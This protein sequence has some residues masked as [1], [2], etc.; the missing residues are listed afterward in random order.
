[1]ILELVKTATG[2]IGSHSQAE[3]PLINGSRIFLEE[4]G[5]NEWLKNEETP[6]I[7]TA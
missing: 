3:A 1:V 5:R 6:K 7:D 4:C 2:S